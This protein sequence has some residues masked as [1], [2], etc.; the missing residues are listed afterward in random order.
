[1]RWQGRRVRVRFFE[2]CE[3]SCE[4]ILWISIRSTSDIILSVLFLRNTSGKPFSRGLRQF[5]L[6]RVPNRGVV[7]GCARPLALPRSRP[8]LDRSH[9]SCPSD[10]PA[11]RPPFLS[12]Q[13]IRIC[14]LASTLIQHRTDLFFRDW[15]SVGNP[16]TALSN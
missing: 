12:P 8:V 9:I 6:E 15:I 3:P 10:V 1:M 13:R 5:H 2:L 7:G 4:L 16:A 11:S 14:L